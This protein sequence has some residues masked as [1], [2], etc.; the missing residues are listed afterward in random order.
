M[1][2]KKMIGIVIAGIIV[3]AASL[4]FTGSLLAG[5][6]FSRCI[7][8]FCMHRGMQR[9]MMGM[10]MLMGLN[11]SDAQKDQVQA[12]IMEHRDQMENTMA[13]LRQTMRETMFNAI[14]AEEFDEGKIRDAFRE[15]APARE[16][17]IVQRA[18]M[19][20]KIKTIL[21]PEQ[22]ELLKEWKTQMMERRGRGFRQMMFK[23]CFQNSHG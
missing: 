16:E 10:N 1:K 8:G 2:S 14:F 7:S 19:I 6:N 18:K 11:L 13:E 12:I 20:A 23:S 15:T 22:V 5:R 9:G 3:I 21:D 4:I 17:M